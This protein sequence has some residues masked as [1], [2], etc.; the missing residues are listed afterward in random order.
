MIPEISLSEIQQRGYREDGQA[1]RKFEQR[2]RWIT[3]PA[4]ATV[5]GGG[6]LFASGH[7]IPG[8][9]LVVAGL[10]FCIGA[11]YHAA[12]SMPLSSITGRPM[13]RYRR[14]DSLREQTEFIYVD[15]ESCTYF[16]RLI[17]SPTT[18]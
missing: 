7:F 11:A 16:V 9:I 8:S 12:R 17:S 15:D 1:H 13:Q 4:I 5:L 6:S 10:V 14:T 2:Y 3:G 18:E